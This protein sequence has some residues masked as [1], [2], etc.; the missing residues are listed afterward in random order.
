MNTKWDT[1]KWWY[2]AIGLVVVVA[3]LGI[4]YGIFR[5][6]GLG[7]EQ[8]LTQPPIMET[9]PEQVLTE[10]QI[11][12]EGE[13]T[14]VIPGIE[15]GLEP[16]AAISVPSYTLDMAEVAAETRI[17]PVQI[18]FAD[19]ATLVSLLG[20]AVPLTAEEEALMFPGEDLFVF[21]EETSLISPFDEDIFYFPPVIGGT[22]PEE[23][24]QT[25]VEGIAPD[26]PVMDEFEPIEAE[27]AV[28][29]AEED[30]PEALPSDYRPM[31]DDEY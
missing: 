29:P 19:V 2:A 4:G 18:T 13:E 31:E 21:P 24:V 11:S 12:P 23:T 17:L 1:R 8:V 15:V 14:A 9:G 26:L 22:L 25:P 7:Q 16:E 6:P 10:P 27:T 30:N 3:L 20:P 5:G 28:V